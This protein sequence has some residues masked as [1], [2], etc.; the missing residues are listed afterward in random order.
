MRRAPPGGCSGPATPW[1]ATQDAALAFYRDKLGFV[2]DT[3]GTDMA[4]R[5]RFGNQIRVTQRSGE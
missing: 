4:I 5:D 2:V 3:D 1:I